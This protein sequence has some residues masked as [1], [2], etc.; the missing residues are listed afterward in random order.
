MNS[1]LSKYH[2]KR[3]FE[4]TSEPRGQLRS[5]NS[6][7][8]RFAVQ[9]HLATRDHFDFRL[10]WKGV[11]LSWAVPK[12]PSYNTNDKRLAVRVEDHP[13][14]YRDFEGVI[15]QGE[16]GGGTVMLWDEGYW[17][18]RYDFEKGLDKGAIKIMLY[19][20]R[21]KGKWALVKIKNEEDKDNWLLIKEKDQF[22]KRTPGIAKLTTSI[23]TGRNFKE[24]EAEKDIPHKRTN[25]DPKLEFDDIKITHP[26]RVVFPKEK[27]TKQEVIDYYKKVSNRMLK[28]LGNRLIS[29]VRCNKGVNGEC[30]F[31]KHPLKKR[32]G[33]KIKSITTSIGEKDDYYFITG[34]K[35]IIYEAQLGTVEFHTWG[36]QQDRLEHPDMMV[37]DLDP[38]AGMELEQIRQGVRDLKKVLDKLH[39]K[40]FLKTSGGKGYH[41]VVPFKNSSNWVVFHDFAQNVARFMEEEWPEKYTS[42]VRK[43]KRK[44]K[45][46]IDWIRNGRGATS[47]SPYSLR[48]RPGAKVSMPISWRE[49]DRIAPDGIDMKEAIRRLSKADPWKDFYNIE[50]TLG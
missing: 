46:F 20:K 37:F 48:A 4:K 31:K 5:L 49:L 43:S 22:I 8:L 3:N 18:P 33:I 19:G 34:P 28:Y 39:L 42:N 36:S 11:L 10:E 17:E 26:E 15:P 13:L 47:I 50:Q 25:G 44:G 35:G 23:K 29:V 41:V 38:D 40:S 1:K 7:K 30:F 14:D 6:I 9:H 45:I 16:Y 12:G 32:D 2:E 24:I 27:I 21:L